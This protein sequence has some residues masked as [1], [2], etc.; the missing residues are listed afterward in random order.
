M[1][2]RKIYYS[3]QDIPGGQSY[4]PGYSSNVRG[5]K[6]SQTEIIQIL[7][8]IGVL[9]IAFA[10]ALAPNPPL[11]NISHAVN[12][13]PLAF[14]A[15]ITAFMCHEFAHKYVAQR[16]GYWSEFR[17]YP[18]G[19]L[20]ALIFGVLIGFVFAAPGAVTIFGNPNKEENGK[21]AI[22]GPL[23]NIVICS[24]A[25]LIWLIIPGVIGNIAFFISFINAFL[26]FFNLLPIGPMDGLKI[27][28][29]R[30]EIWIVTMIVSVIILAFLILM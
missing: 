28:S 7:I 24:I 14:I 3:F 18:Q 1:S 29:W 20:F 15:I 19:L 11:Q 2:E 22:A 6:F 8:A 21:M 26:A 13:I 25:I 5:L 27:L 17:M 9:T 23:T 16:Y 4:Q 12:N 10:F 30:R